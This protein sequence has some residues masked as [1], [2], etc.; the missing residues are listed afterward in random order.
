M[1]TATISYSSIKNAASEAKA[2]SRKLDTYADRLTNQVYNKLNNYNGSYTGN[3]SNAITKTNEKILELRRKCTAYERYSDDLYDL[4]DECENTDRTVRLMVSRLTADFKSN[5]GI[6][7]NPIINAINYY[8]VSLDNSN[9]A[10]RWVNSTTD[11]T[12]GVKEYIAQALED[13]WD[14][15]GGKQLVKGVL[16]GVIKIAIAVATVVGL[17]LTSTIWGTIAAVAA[18]IGAAIAVVNALVN[19]GNEFRAYN[20]TQNGDPALAR[21]RS[22]EDTLSDT[23]CRETDSKELH[24]LAGTIDFVELVCDIISIV[25][26]V[27]DIAVNGFK[28]IKENKISLESIKNFRGKLG[29]GIGDI[30]KTIHS[31]DWSMITR[32]TARFK[33]NFIYNLKKNFCN[34]DSIKDGAKTVKNYLN[35]SK[36][37]IKDGFSLS[38]I[39]DIALKKVIIPC[40]TVFTVNKDKAKIV[41]FLGKQMQIDDLDHVTVKDFYDL[42]DD[43]KELTKSKLFSDDIVNIEVL[44]KL[45]N[46]SIVSSA[47]PPVIV[48]KITLEIPK[49][50][51]PVIPIYK[52]AYI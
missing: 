26:G 20:E 40:S 28:W 6:E 43:I 13:W 51:I 18:V 49:I 5:N 31:N 7:N 52:Q 34:F 33:D 23:L 42:Y 12:A 36:G 41:G 10:G 29:D 3:I 46:P 22:N 48:P 27:K 50:E 4:K 25:D 30:G 11:K 37:L 17:T 45:S 24:L 1:S 15:N 38:N 21:R 44:K 47:I 35:I 8:L 9:A 14:Y 32:F 2:V 16:E 19:I 39:S